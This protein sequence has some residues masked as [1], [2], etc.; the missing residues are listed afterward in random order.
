MPASGA[1]PEWEDRRWEDETGEIV[2]VERPNPLDPD[3]GWEPVAVP[4]PTYTMKPMAPRP[5]PRPW[6]GE[7]DFADDLDL[8]AV[9]AKRR[10]VNG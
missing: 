10:A 1:H 8:D 9:L 5:Q 2:G 7:R 6:E 4:P 3:D